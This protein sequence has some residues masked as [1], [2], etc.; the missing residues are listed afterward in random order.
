[1]RVYA[2]L[3]GELVKARDGEDVLV[4]G[5]AAA[6]Y[7]AHIEALMPLLGVDFDAKAIKPVRTRPHIGP[8][9]Y[10]DVRSGALAQLRARGDWLTCDELADGILG[11]ERVSL[12]VAQRRHFKQKLREALHALKA[13]GAVEPEHELKLGEGQL[14]QRWRLS[15]TLFRSRG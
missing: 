13:A 2:R 12:S 7:M 5:A 15:R 3:K 1:L 9:G 11:Q 10:G 14:V 8:L 6:G 4:D